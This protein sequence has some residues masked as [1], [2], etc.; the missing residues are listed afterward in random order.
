MSGCSSSH[1][2]I[3]MVFH[4]VADLTAALAGTAAL[5]GDRLTVTGAP[6]PDLVDRLAHTAAFGASPEVKG[7][8]RWVIL[9][10]AAHTGVRFASIHDLYLAMGRGEAGGFTVPAINVRAMAYDTGRAVFRAANRLDAGAFILEIARSEIGYTEQRPHEYAA[11]MAAAALRE[12]FR[13]P[14]FLQGDHVQVNAKK[15]ASPDR[16]KELDTL[17]GLIREEIAAGFYNID[18]DTSTLVDLDQP[19]LAEQQAV[20]CELAAEFTAFIRRHEPEGVTVS[21]GGEIGEVGGKNSDIH[22]LHAF[23]KGYYGALTAKGDGLVGI[24]KISVQTGT[25]HG[26][27]VGP[28]GKVKSDV[29]IDLDTLQELSRVAREQYGLAGAVQHGAS[30]LSA[31]AFDAF[32][33]VGACEIHLATNFQN[34]VYDH[35]AF[36]AA[37][38][39]EMY[40]WV[41]EHAQEEKKPKDTDEQFLYKARKKAI[42]PFKSRLWE[43]PAATRETI[44]K[45]L[46]DQFAFLMSKLRIPGTSEV[47]AKFVTPATTLPSLENARLAAAG[48]ITSEE[49][50]AEGL[51]D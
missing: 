1:E 14:L 44:G 8:A 35:P 33:R 47:V 46:E 38:K 30:T 7:T 28:D 25:A 23:M 3:R 9:N 21:V 17:R 24:S 42:G 34:M 32:P 19:T 12:G 20:N 31:E 41:R 43:L 51:A 10:L 11:I 16:D 22:E 50:K 4:S 2:G 37:L 48:K 18:I 29:K 15:H 36:P 6:A 13:G 27:F 39:D 49:R 26:G 45:T 40:A 5:S